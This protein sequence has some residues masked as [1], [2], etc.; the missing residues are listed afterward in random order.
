MKKLISLVVLT[1]LVLGTTFAA[2]KKTPAL[3]LEPIEIES[4]IQTDESGTTYEVVPT[5]E[6]IG[7][8]CRLAQYN[9][10]LDYYNGDNSYTQ[11][12]DSLYSKYKDHKAVKKAIA[13]K[14]KGISSGAMA[15]L[16][17]YI[18]PDFSGTIIDFEPLPEGLNPRWQKIKTKEIYDFITL[19]HDFAKE[20]NYSRIFLLVKPDLLSGVAYFNSDSTKYHISEFAKKFFNN[21]P[22]CN[23]TISVNMISPGYWYDGWTVDSNENTKL[24]GTIYPSCYFYDYLRTYFS[25]ESLPVANLIWDDVKDNLLKVF[26]AYTKLIIQDEKKFEKY[27]KDFIPFSPLVSEY[28]SIFAIL[29][30]LKTPEYLDSIKD[31]DYPLTYEVAFASLEKELDGGFFYDAIKLFEEYSANRDKYPSLTDFAPKLVEFINSIPV[32][33]ATP[34]SEGE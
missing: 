34:V 8:I 2:P 25:A 6:V 10:F 7:I 3:Q 24:Y 5:F 15:S 26:M 11:R 33:S 17:Y 18:K 30:Y 27:Q 23:T 29:E 4:I 20:T 31:E 1:T 21:S 12:I 14:N 32:P 19:V 13:L 28:I 9:E 22:N 16:A